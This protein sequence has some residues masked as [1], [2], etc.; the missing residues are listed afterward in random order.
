M[1]VDRQPSPWPSVVILAGLLFLCLMAPRYWRSGV[2]QHDSP[3]GIE[4]ELADDDWETRYDVHPFDHTQ[5]NSAAHFFNLDGIGAGRFTGAMKVDLLNVCPPPSIEEL[6]AAHTAMPRPRMR[7][8]H[9]NADGFDWP[10]LVR[11]AM[12]PLQNEEANSEPGPVLTGETRPGPQFAAPFGP[13]GR[14]ASELATLQN[15][16]RM[17]E[18][19][20]QFADVAPRLM[21]SFGERYESLAARF[22]DGQANA[23][24]GPALVRVTSPDDRLAMAI[25][26]P[27][28]RVR[29]WCVPQT[30]LEKLDRLA[31]Q[32]ES[33]Q[34]AS[35]VRNQLHALTD[36]AELAGDDV[37]I[38]MADL[39]AAAQEA[40][41]MANETDNDQLRVELLRVHWGLARRLDCWGAIHENRV[42]AHFQSRVAA[43]GPLNPYLKGGSDPAVT[44]IEIAALGSELE[45]YEI[46]RDP[47]LARKIALQKK[48]L[49]ASTDATDRAVAESLEQHYRNANLRV[50]IT[51]EMLNRLAGVERDEWQPV[52]SQIA[53]A[54]VRGQSNVHS[55]S[56]VLLDPSADEWLLE[57]KADGV[58]DSN[59]MANSGP[60]RFRSRGTTDFAGRKQIVVNDKGIHLKESD[61]NASCSNRLVGVT[62][63]YD[64][65]PIIGG[66]ARDRA[67]NEYR[68]R[69]GHVRSQI[70]DRVATDARETLDEQTRKAV[71]QIRKQTYDRFASELDAFDIKLTPIEMKTTKE[72]LVARLR[73]AGENQLG[74]NTPRPRA[75]SDSLASAQLHETALTNLAITL[76]LDG[77]RYTAPELRNMLRQ[78]FPQLATK[79][80]VEA[81]Q[82]TIF[83]FAAHDAVQVHINDGRFELAVSFDSIEL[84]GD[85][86]R[87]VVIHAYYTPKIDGLNA[88][89]VRDG[90]LGVEGRFSAGDRARLHNIF[91]RVLPQERHLPIVQIENTHDKRFEGLMITQL[92]LEDGWAGLAVGPTT[93][94]RVA[95]RSR[96]LR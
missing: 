13:M 38:I 64:W 34:W 4:A 21:L 25:V 65:L 37:Q 76:G 72:R 90:T 54:Y 92:V 83:Q 9:V 82:E 12:G 86:M 30:L 75:L 58:V 70:E 1:R 18:I 51:A 59:T 52:S 85:V 41:Q 71:D 78:K 20:N 22:H 43:R 66:M 60:V 49:E 7:A 68:S 73:V 88:E 23:V 40:E 47:R 24:H 50:A 53:G 31:G 57:L 84:D 81:K 89:L 19:A 28:P 55:E 69:Q 77:K 62:T 45:Q 42:A 56:H 14:L 48:T 74:S 36:R 32:P 15:I 17:W 27:Q 91:N 3:I 93:E 16:V 35:Q 6:V 8:R 61:M 11:E 46:T 33:A 29:P 26:P 80:A 96:S 63:D 94:A 39:S 5:L 79:N 10:V 87:G 95:E 67:I 2:V 44:P